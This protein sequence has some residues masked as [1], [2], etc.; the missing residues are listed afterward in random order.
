[1]FIIYHFLFVLIHECVC[2]N[3]VHRPR[4]SDDVD[5]PAPIDMD[6][7]RIKNKIDSRL[8]GFYFLETPRDTMRRNFFTWAMMIDAANPA[9]VSNSRCGRFSISFLALCLCLCARGL[10][11]HNLHTISFTAVDVPSLSSMGSCLGSSTL[12]LPKKVSSTG[13]TTSPW[14]PPRSVVRVNIWKNT[15]KIYVCALAKM[16]ID[17]HVEKMA[18]NTGGPVPLTASTSLSS[19]VPL[20][21]LKAWPMCAL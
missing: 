16:S 10:V 11:A 21:S 3:S 19:T 15:M 1:M 12:S 7:T 17:T 2:F 14:N 13:S 18:L 5:L 4:V 20:A 8:H 9:Y 6:I